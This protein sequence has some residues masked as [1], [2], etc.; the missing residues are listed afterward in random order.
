[1]ISWKE[2]YRIGVD[3]IDEQHMKLLEIADSAYELLQNELITDKY[4]KI[5]EIIDEL[6]DYT[7]YHFRS[8]E[9]YMTA[10]GYKKLLSQKVDHDD[11]IEKMNDIDLNKVDNGQNE[12]LCGILA[13]V[14]EWIDS[15]IL[16]KDKLIVDQ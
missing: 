4:D 3:S 12:Y 2:E 5:V 15:H 9:A 11:F 14:I 1:M 7:V 16:K 8:E 13:F 10:I 6:K